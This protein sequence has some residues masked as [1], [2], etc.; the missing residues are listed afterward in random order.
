MVSRLFKQI[1]L[2][3]SH[4]ALLSARDASVCIVKLGFVAV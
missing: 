3:P 4:R 1:A 2:V